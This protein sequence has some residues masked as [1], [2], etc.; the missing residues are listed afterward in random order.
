MTGRALKTPVVFAPGPLAVGVPAYDSDMT[1]AFDATSGTDYRF[2]D[3]LSG[4]DGTGDPSIMMPILDVYPD[5]LSACMPNDL[6]PVIVPHV[7]DLPS[8]GCAPSR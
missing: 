7:A 2:T 5:A 3:A 4:S 8:R 6:V 1:A